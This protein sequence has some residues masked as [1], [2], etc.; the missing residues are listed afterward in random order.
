MAVRGERK[1]VYTFLMGNP[2]V[3]DFSGDVGVDGGQH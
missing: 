3:C 1:Q 2:D